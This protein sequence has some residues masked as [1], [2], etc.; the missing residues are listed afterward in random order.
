MAALSSKYSR[1][2]VR[3]CNGL[4]LR[5]DIGKALRPGANEI[6]ARVANLINDNY[7]E[8]TEYGLLDPMRP[9]RRPGYSANLGQKAGWLI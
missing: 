7:G 2:G 3:V 8:F 6:Q 9:V 4:R 1:D 5:F